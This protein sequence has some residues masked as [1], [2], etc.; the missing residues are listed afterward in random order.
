MLQ[1]KLQLGIV[2]FHLSITSPTSKR[3]IWWLFNTVGGIYVLVTTTSGFS[4]QMQLDSLK[5]DLCELQYNLMILI[6]FSRRY[7][8]CLCE[9]ISDIYGSLMVFKCQQLR[10]DQFL[11]RMQAGTSYRQF[12]DFGAFTVKSGIWMLQ[13]KLQL[14]IMISHHSTIP[15]VNSKVK[16]WFL[17]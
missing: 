16:W 8:H 11:H 10:E 17:M 6:S 15:P 9:I 3:M 13:M 12:S 1:M 14:S 4:R 5:S 2:L 7:L